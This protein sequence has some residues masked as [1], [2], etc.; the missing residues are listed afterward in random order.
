MAL[1]E[2]I[3]SELVRLGILQSLGAIPDQLHMAGLAVG[4][5]VTLERRRLGYRVDPEAKVVEPS[6]RLDM[7]PGRYKVLFDDTEYVTVRF[8]NGDSVVDKGPDIGWVG[9]EEVIKDDEETLQV[10]LFDDRGE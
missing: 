6:V 5:V 1:R 10:A 9:F 7:P 3:Y 4:N 8:Q 2:K